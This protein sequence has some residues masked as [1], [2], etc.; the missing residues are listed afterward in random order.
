MLVYFTTQT[1]MVS[2][3]QRDF[4]LI[5]I[6]NMSKMHNKIFSSPVQMCRKSYC[7]SP[8]IP[9][10]IAIGDGG[11]SRDGVSVHKM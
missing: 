7:T 1:E 10:G 5:F 8:G 4:D 9:G 6:F 11:G 2:F 3:L